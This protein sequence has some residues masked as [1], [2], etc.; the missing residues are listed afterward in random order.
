MM[1]SAAKLSYRQAQAALDHAPDEAAAPLCAHVLVPLYEAYRA[2]KIARGKRGP[3]DLDLPERKILLDE[4]GAVKSVVTPPRL[5]SHRLIEEF[6]ILA[7]VAA[8]ETL[9][10][11]TSGFHLSRA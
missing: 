7:N 11:E 6:M 9:E 3:L 8:A 4:N 5:D 10:G 1:R 2:L